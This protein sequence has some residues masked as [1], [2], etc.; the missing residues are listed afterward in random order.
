MDCHGAATA[1]AAKAHEDGK[2][3]SRFVTASLTVNYLTPTP[4]DAELTL[5]AKAVEIKGRKVSVEMML[6]AAGKVCVTG[7]AL[8]IEVKESSQP[9]CDSG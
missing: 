2:P 6:L 1:A 5:K 3:V 7:S 4:I 9:G 8:M